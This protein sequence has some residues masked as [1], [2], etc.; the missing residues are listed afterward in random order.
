[1]PEAFDTVR[2]TTYVPAVGNITAT[3][4]CVLVEGAPEGKLQLHEVA[5]PPPEESV[6]EIA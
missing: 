2:E 6:K 4:L 3:D 1:V 5:G